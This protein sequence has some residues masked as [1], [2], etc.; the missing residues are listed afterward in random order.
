M[1]GLSFFIFRREGI[2]HYF[3]RN[4]INLFR[5]VAWTG[6]RPRRPG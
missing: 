5:F 2:R 3:N 6:G 4:V 1:Q